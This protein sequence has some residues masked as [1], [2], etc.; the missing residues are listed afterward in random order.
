MKWYSISCDYDP[1]V[2]G[3]V[4]TFQSEDMTDDY[5][6]AGDN[7]IRT[8]ASNDFDYRRFR[9]IDFGRIKL[10]SAA[11]YTDLI[12]CVRINQ[13]FVLI[14]S[15]AF[16]DYL[17]EFKLPETYEKEVG[18]VH[19]KLNMERKY[20][21]F[22]V[23]NQYSIIDHE[24]SFFLVGQRGEPVEQYGRKKFKDKNNF[25]AFLDTRPGNTRVRAEQLFVKTDFDVIRF[26]SLGGYYVSEQLKQA[27]EYE[28]FTGIRFEPAAYLQSV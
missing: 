5:N 4:Q 25:K 9:E 24:Q 15:Q 7:A 22:Y 20:K 14:M 27:I 6:Y 16:S 10:K 21:A 11:I 2:I 3:N 18:V 17:K 12:S 23:D 13:F 1:K 26:R 19:P 28:N 8:I